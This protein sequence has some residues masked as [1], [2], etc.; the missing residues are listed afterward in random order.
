VSDPYP[1][2]V[3]DRRR[4]LAGAPRWWSYYSEAVLSAGDVWSD[5][6]PD[7]WR[8]W[9]FPPD[10]ESA[11]DLRDLVRR[12]NRAVD[13]V[14][15]ILA[16]GF[17][18]FLLAGTWSA[19]PGISGIVDAG[20]GLLACLALFWRRRY[21][22]AVACFAIAGSA[23]AAASAG[24]SLIALFGAAARLR[25]V[26]V[27]VLTV[28]QLIA[29]AIFPLLYADQHGYPYAT[30]LLIGGLV[31][32]MLVGWGLVVGLSRR[33]LATVVE[34]ADLRRVEQELRAAHAQE[35]ERRRIAHEMHEALSPR[36]SLLSVHAGALEYRP[37]LTSESIREIGNVIRL[38]SH[39]ALEDL[40]D[41][42]WAL[43]D[44]NEQYALLP[45]PGLSDLAALVDE[46]R[47]AYA[48]VHFHWDVDDADETT[49]TRS[50]ASRTAYRIVREGLT[51]ARKH[52]PDSPIDVTLDDDGAVLV[53]RVRTQL[54]EPMPVKPMP[55]SG[56]GLAGIAERVARE[57]GTFDYGRCEEEF[58]VTARL[59]WDR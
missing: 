19:H 54:P 9:L 11:S 16:A 8:L 3:G 47:A 1:T 15:L 2:K 38:A 42:I 57:D 50:R 37:D 4:L 20:I 59:R 36:L 7:R 40:N 45:E 41:A 18:T 58:I 30:Q 25:P 43:R 24:A 34:H 22:F 56:S 53:V 28:A 17:G 10:P 12:R 5:A 55:G 44:R 27:L 39:D 32:L 35:A 31:N 13:T 6:A 29:V 26:L 51:N 14:C 23:V 52:A 49:Q 46:S 21:P 48:N 33:H